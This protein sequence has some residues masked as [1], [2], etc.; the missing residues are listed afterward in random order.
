MRIVSPNFDL[1][2][3][4]SKSN[5]EERFKK[6]IRYSDPIKIKKQYLSGQREFLAVIVIRRLY[7]LKILFLKIFQKNIR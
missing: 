2:Y 3:N 4:L 1:K 5:I 7:N 6:I